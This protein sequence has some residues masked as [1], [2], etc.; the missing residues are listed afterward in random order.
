MSRSAIVTW[1]ILS[2]CILVGCRHRA[3][4]MDAPT[5]MTRPHVREYCWW[6]VLRSSRSPDSVGARFKRAYEEL[7]LS[8]VS[9]GRWGDT[10]W[11][12]A[13][14]SRVSTRMTNASYESGALAYALGD[15]THFRYFVAITAPPGGWIRRSDSVEATKGD[16]DFCTDI[17]RHAAIGWTA[18]NEPAG[19]ESLPLWS[20]D[21]WRTSHQDSAMQQ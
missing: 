5:A 15:S 7:E 3:E 8:T 10:V 1:S 11:A 13:G 6:A 9:T 14:P 19:E 12:H 2:S 4:P 16:I 17:A 21:P 18:P 20:A